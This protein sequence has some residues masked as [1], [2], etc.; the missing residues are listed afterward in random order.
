MEQVGW[1]RRLPEGRLQ[2]LSILPVGDAHT[3]PSSPLQSSPPL[4]VHNV[5]KFCLGWAR[6]RCGHSCGGP[7][8]GGLCDQAFY[9]CQ[10]LCGPAFHRHDC[11]SRDGQLLVVA[12]RSTCLLRLNS[13][14][15]CTPPAF[16]MYLLGAT[17]ATSAIQRAHENVARDG[18]L[19]AEIA[20]RTWLVGIRRQVLLVM[21]SC[22]IVRSHPGLPRRTPT[23]VG[24]LQN[25]FGGQK[26]GHHVWAH[27]V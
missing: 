14:G 18:T 21:R 3:Y 26:N 15:S 27:H 1:P 13:I 17:A 20:H 10:G 4:P 24:C 19:Q 2:E 23:R 22:A 25:R 6:A 7:A 5:G 8:C 16:G 12:G 9:H 11:P